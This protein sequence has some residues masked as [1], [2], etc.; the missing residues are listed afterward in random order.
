MKFF[1]VIISIIL[2]FLSALTFIVLGIPFLLLGVMSTKYLF[3]YIPFFCRILLLTMGVRLRCVGEFPKNQKYIIMCNHTSFI[4]VF[5]FPC[6]INGYFTAISAKKNF[7]IP[8]FGTMLRAIKAIPIDRTNKKNAIKSIQAAELVIE[9][10]K[11]NIVILPEG[12]RTLDGKLQKFKKGG[13]HMAKNTKT[14]I[15]PLVSVGSFEYKPK[16]RFTLRPRLVTIYIGEPINT[17][18]ESIENLMEKTYLEMTTLIEG[19]K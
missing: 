17:N 5:T 12:T 11:F 2:Y 16:N 6:F 7:Y 1:N 10:T 3:K 19:A 14:N 8:L 4:D 15:L 9:K 13:F 18:N